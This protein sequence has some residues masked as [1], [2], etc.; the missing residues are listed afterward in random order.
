MRI[1]LAEDETDMSRAITAILNHNGYDVDAVYDGLS[2]VDKASFYA[3]DCIILDIMMPKLDG[4]EALKRIR[5]AGNMSPVIMLTAKS[6]VNDRITGL[7]A[8]ADDYLTKPFAM[9]ELLARI[10]S[11]TRRMKTY[12]PQKLTFG[13]VTLNMEDYALTCLTTIRL[14][15]KEAHLLQLFLLNP[16]KEISSQELNDKIWHQNAD[17]ETVY[18]YISYLRGKLEAVN[19]DIQ[20]SGDKGGSFRLQKQ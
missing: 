12:T 16:E 14:G 15:R 5:L 17:H 19:A 20:I 3:Y 10:R 13:S 2:A 4:I 1:L 7:D 11:L 8:G 9:A 18:L 6:E